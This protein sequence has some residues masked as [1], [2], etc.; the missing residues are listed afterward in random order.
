MKPTPAHP[1]A[2][3]TLYCA[4]CGFRVKAPIE[5][6]NRFCTTCA[7]RRAFRVRNRI[8][9]ILKNHRKKA[10][11]TLKMITLSTSNC[12]DLDAGVNQL[13]AA[14]RRLRQRDIW[15]NHVSGGAT[16]IEVTGRP[17][18][19]H[20]H[21]HILCYS[22]FIPWQKLRSAWTK[23]SAGTAVYIQNVDDSKA[24][25]YVTKYITKS[26]VPAFLSDDLSKVLSR[27]RL[28]QRFGDWHSLRIPKKLYDYPCPNCT[29]STWIVDL[30]IES[31]CR[32][33]AYIPRSVL[34]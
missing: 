20:P 1:H 12:K 13:V 5:C 27:F 29:R 11:H 24:L 9:W 31:A 26:D 10:G 19:W 4:G 6:G 32:D 21:L 23:V 22:R 25:A 17:N 8:R 28:F 2:F 18:D 15:K 34:S 30:V 14:F 16:V 7:P 3:R 33:P